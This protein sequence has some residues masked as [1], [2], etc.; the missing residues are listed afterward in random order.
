L[1]DSPHSSD[2]NILTTIG[3]ILWRGGVYFCAGYIAFQAFRQLLKLL[4]WVDLPAQIL[5]A[6]SCAGGGI[7]LILFSLILERI[8]DAK[9]EKGLKD[10]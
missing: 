4:L 1:A 10:G 6:V 3:M 8:Q 5:L 2:R 9:G 7:L